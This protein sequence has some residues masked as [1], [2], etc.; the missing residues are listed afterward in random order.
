MS[1][2]NCEDH[3]SS[4]PH[5]WKEDS[6]RW[7]LCGGGR[8]RCLYRGQVWVCGIFNGPLWMSYSKPAPCPTQH[9]SWD[10]L[11][12]AKNFFFPFKKSTRFAPLN[13]LTSS[14]VGFLSGIFMQRKLWKY[15]LW[16]KEEMWKITSMW[17]WTKCKCATMHCWELLRLADVSSWWTFRPE[18]NC[19]DGRFVRK[20]A[21][22]Q[23]TF[24]P[25]GRF[26]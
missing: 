5:S 24:R 23:Q 3:H 13:F 15:L 22:Y 2:L 21:E 18:T 9:R 6:V 19:P 8:S 11:E 16:C 7:K 10:I 12:T 4:S 26:V 25:D 1:T 20:M 14:N 17:I